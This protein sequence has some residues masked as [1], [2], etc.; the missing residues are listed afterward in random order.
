MPITPG[1]RLGPYEIRGTLGAGGMG[2]VY[3]AFD[4]R[5]H[6]DVA[7]KVLPESVTSDVHRARLEREARAVAALSHPNV[8]SV[9]DVG[10]Q[11][12]V[13]Y[14]VSELLEGKTLRQVLRDGALAPGIVVDYARQAAHALQAAHAKG[15]IHRDIKPEN[16]FVTNDGRLKVLDF[17]LVA[18]ATDPD[19]ATAVHEQRLTAPDTVLGTIGYMSPEQLRAQ[20]VDHR[21]DIFSL[22]CVIFEMLAGRPPFLRGTQTATVAAILNDPPDDTPLTNVPSSL[23]ALVQRCLAKD[24]GERYASAAA[25]ADDLRA[26]SEAPTVAFASS[27][28]GRAKR[29]PRFA[30]GG[31]IVAAAVTAALLVPRAGQQSAPQPAAAAGPSRAMVAVLPFENLSG[32]PAQEYFSDGLTEDTT[33]EFGR[34]SPDRLGV[35]ARTS[36][37]RYK[38]ARADVRTI[39]RELGV[40]YVVEGSVRRAGDRVRVAAQLVRTSDGT[41]LWSQIYDRTLDDVFA[42]QSELARDVATA[43]EIKVL[44]TPKNGTS[45]AVLSAAGRDALLRGRHHLAINTAE[46]RRKAV[47]YMQQALETDPQSA[48]VHTGMARALFSMSTID[49]PPHEVVPKAREAVTKALELDE[50]LPEAH[51]LLGTMLLEYYWEWD[52]AERAMKRAIALNPNLARAHATY[53]TLLIS[54]GRTEEGMQHA[55]R[56][57]VLDPLAMTQHRNYLVQLYAGRR[58]DDAIDQARKV[59][60][61]EPQYD[62]AYAIA[63]VAH[64]ARNERE[65]AIVNA[66]KVIT[67]SKAPV[68]RAMA[69]YVFANAGLKEEAETLMSELQAAAEKRFVC[70]FNI[71]TVHTALGEKEKAFE[72][73]ERAIRDRSG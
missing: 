10:T 54:S 36:V 30:I 14:I 13:F 16:L 69:A 40:D 57:R 55:A 73:L 6:R 63:G 33:S 58:W 5:L 45:A 49:F 20:P 29:I 68:P 27:D 9:F 41:H 23:I 7:I 18:L 35:I 56:A 53:A 42:I 1:D 19:G 50:S 2:V 3:R 71:A 28:Q 8:V 22:G 24:R 34:L 46:D 48:E 4:T 11:G 60:H 38:K 70:F 25:L 67:M 39:G 62:M 65:A 17:G 32:D 47:A 43:V 59:I 52:E 72:D 66:K 61:Q 44:P 51:E 64:L 12:D 31:L 26:P 15:I 21:T 37:M